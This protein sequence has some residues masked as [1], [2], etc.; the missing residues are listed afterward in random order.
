MND[1]D[2]DDYLSYFL[3]ISGAQ[4]VS[5]FESTFK[6][7]STKITFDGNFSQFTY[8]LH[9]LSTIPDKE[10]KKKNRKEH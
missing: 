8:K 2:N 1:D 5:K 10:K 6:S 4:F 3:S 9:I 7:T